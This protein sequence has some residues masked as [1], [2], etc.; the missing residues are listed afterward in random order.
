MNTPEPTPDQLARLAALLG[1]QVQ[2]PTDPQRTRSSIRLDSPRCLLQ[3][4]PIWSSRDKWHAWITDTEGRSIHA[5]PSA[6]VSPSRT[7][8]AIAADIRRRVL[9]PARSVLIAH[10]TRKNTEHTREQD[11]A[12][13]IAALEAVTGHTNSPAHHSAEVVRLPGIRITN[14][15][16]LQADH[17]GGTYRLEIDVHSFDCLRMIARLIAEDHR[18]HDALRA[19]RATP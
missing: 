8:E 13:K 11:L 18:V 4:G 2:A 17:Y 3:I 7:L 12:Q 5:S 6:N 19:A 9:D 1:G 16:H 14:R 15:Y 10:E